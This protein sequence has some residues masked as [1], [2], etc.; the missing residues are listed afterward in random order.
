MVSKVERAPVVTPGGETP[1]IHSSVSRG[2]IPNALRQRCAALLQT[3][4]DDRE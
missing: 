2:A 3:S 4:Y 1:S